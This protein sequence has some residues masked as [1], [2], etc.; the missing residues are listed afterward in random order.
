MSLFWG[1]YLVL[2]PL[3][4]ANLGQHIV[5][6]GLFAQNFRLLSEVGYF[7]EDALRKPLLHLWSLAVEEQFYIVF[8]ILIVILWKLFES[9]RLIG[10]AVFSITVLSFLATIFINKGFGFYF[11]FT[12]FWELG[13]G[14]IIAYLETYGIASGS[15]LNQSI[16]SCVSVLALVVLILLFVFYK[17][18]WSHPGFITL[19]PVFASVA[20]ISAYPDALINRTLLSIK[21]MTFVGLISYSLYLWHWPLLCF[22]FICLPETDIS[23]SYKLATLFLSFLL[24]T[25]VYK[26]IENP[27][28]RLKS[29]KGLNVSLLLMLL[30][31][32]MIG[33]G[34]LLS[35]FEGLPQRSFVQNHLEIN[36]IAKARVFHEWTAYDNLQKINVKGVEFGVT[37][38]SESPSIVFL[39]DS[40]M[41][42]Y[43]LRINYLANKTNTTAASL[44]LR[45][46]WRPDRYKLIRPALSSIIADPRV[47][48][49][50]IASRWFGY[51]G[52]KSGR[53]SLSNLASLAEQHPEKRIFI[54]L[55]P[56][57]DDGSIVNGRRQQ[58]QFDPMRHFNRINYQRDVFL[59][60][61]P[62]E[63]KWEQGNE[64]IKQI[65]DR[66]AK[67]I[68][69]KDFVCDGKLCDTLKYKDDD[70][71]NPYYLES[72]AHWLDGLFDL[73]KE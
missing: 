71:L 38:I 21:P 31:S 70:H 65:F 58:G 16:R 45:S 6:S 57:W 2:L 3:E 46:I 64:M 1:G 4:Y 34:L 12:R 22:L 68:E 60:P 29:I 32:F 73:A 44:A 33:G 13:A 23:A 51:M 17:A 43:Q 48:V 18:H 49:I 63:N 61:Y 26:Y 35:K 69:V 5:S 24:S 53:R 50:V 37:S 39:G 8:P 40:H 72:N 14:I 30:L 52:V 36:Q 19:I 56:P 55:D 27:I 7:T 59:V 9:K 10:I 42:Q 41:A 28:R 47:K 11:P 25:L 62:K 54:L 20:L 67:I 15:R 66:V